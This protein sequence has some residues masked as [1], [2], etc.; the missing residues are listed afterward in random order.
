M[1]SIIFWIASIYFWIM[2]IRNEYSINAVKP[3]YIKPEFAN[4]IRDWT[5]SP[6]TD[7]VVQTKPCEP[8]YE[9][10]FYRLWNGTDVINY[11]D[12]DGSCDDSLKFAPVI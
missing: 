6:Y 12:D 7:V 10:L 4:L 9:P 11:C 3:P 1:C 5:V 8:P 2:E